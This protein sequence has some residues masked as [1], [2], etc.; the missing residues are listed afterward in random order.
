MNFV[1]QIT[2]AVLLSG[3]SLAGLF[4]I[5]LIPKWWMIIVVLF[6]WL[7]ISFC[8]YFFIYRFHS[9]VFA[10]LS[11]FVITQFSF[12]GLVILVEWNFLRWLL[13]I[14]SVVF[15][16]LLAFKSENVESQLSLYYKPIRRMKMMLWVF[17]TYALFTVLFAFDLFFVT[18]PFWILSLF[19]GFFS[20]FVALMIWQMYF[21]SEI[22]QMVFWMSILGMLTIELVW[23][24]SSLPLGYLVLGAF[25]T[26]VWF[27][28]VIFVRFNL[29]PQKIVWHKQAWFLFSNLFLFF[30][31]LF[32]IVRWI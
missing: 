32:F 6:L 17:D 1:K 30:I 7:I 18:V 2:M 14:L 28:M 22:K 25:V 29:G 31:I 19:F 21:G 26:W 3:L 20:G 4:L 8:V 27:I 5:V 15:I 10:N 12:L 24:L 9:D 23:A 13:L 11:L 16:F